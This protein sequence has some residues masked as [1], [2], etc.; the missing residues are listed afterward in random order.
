MY[1]KN[2]K[3]YRSSAFINISNTKKQ[4]EE[5][6]ENNASTSIIYTYKFVI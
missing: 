5:N 3:M 2:K 6:S 1:D 4:S